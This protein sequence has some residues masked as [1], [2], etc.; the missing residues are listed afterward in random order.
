M[1]ARQKSTHLQCKLNNGEEITD[2]IAETHGLSRDKYGE[3][4]LPSTWPH[5]S[6]P[7]R[8]AAEVT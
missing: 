3:S 8:R 5:L 2:A 4:G 7:W 1:L 6:Q